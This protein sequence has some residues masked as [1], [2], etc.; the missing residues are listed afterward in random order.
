[1]NTIVNVPSDGM[2]AKLDRALKALPNVDLNSFVI[3]EKTIRL[4]KALASGKNAYK[5]DFYENPGSDRPQ[6]IKLNRNDMLVI[7]HLAVCIA[8]QDTSAGH[9]GNY[10]LQTF[11]DPG[12]FLGVDGSSNRESDSL[13]MVYNGQLSITTNNVDRLSGL[14]TNHFRY[15]PQRAFG[16]NVYAEYGPDLESRG[17][18]SIEPGIILSG[19]DNNTAEIS[20]GD[21]D[22]SLIAGGI[23]G[24][25]DAVDTSNVLVLLAHG[26]LISEGAAVKV[27]YNTY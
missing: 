14:A 8:Q 9:Y 21:G 17:F 10:P 13:E 20:L 16:S 15:V 6:E 7:T 5:L 11:P 12:V 18:K 26:F 3:H 25:N 19:Q 2:R 24:S 23:D 4:E 22:T 27:R 1:M